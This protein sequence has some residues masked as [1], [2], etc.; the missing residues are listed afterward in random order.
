MEKLELFK[1]QFKAKVHTPHAQ[2]THTHKHEHK[3]TK[4]KHK[5]THCYTYTK[6][7][8][9]PANLSHTRESSGIRGRRGVLEL[10]G[11]HFGW[12]RRRGCRQKS[13][14]QE[15][16]RG[17]LEAALAHIFVSGSSHSNVKAHCSSWVVTLHV[18][19]AC[20]GVEGSSVAHVAQALVLDLKAL[21]ANLEAVHRGNG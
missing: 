11:K 17:V 2:H 15:L 12:Y 1:P 14:R 20:H 8:Q 3:I 21:A 7:L 5:H 6:N 16:P 4:N 19:L 9:A 13:L 18:R 10:L